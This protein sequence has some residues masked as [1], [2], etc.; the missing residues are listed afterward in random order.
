MNKNKFALGM[1]KN[2]TIR[3]LRCMKYFAKSIL[4]MRPERVKQVTAYPLKNKVIV[5]LGDSIFGN[6]DAPNDISTKIAELTG[7]TVYNCGFGGCRMARHVSAYYDPFSMYRL[8]D[9]IVSRDFALQEQ[10]LKMAK[11]DERQTGLLIFKFPKTLSKLKKINFNKVDIVTISYGT[12]DWLG[13]NDLDND[14]DLLDVDSLAGALR[15]SIEKM[16]TK[17]PHLKIF[18]CSP[19]YRCWNNTDGSLDY[20]TDNLSTSVNGVRFIDIIDKQESVARE[21]NLSFVD[22]YHKLGINKINRLQY[23]SVED[24]THPNLAGRQLIAEHIAKCLF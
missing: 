3:F 6:F 2:K 24:G 23:F 15:Y 1:I 7:A 16:L 5:N 12:N 17:Y 20:D 22:N 4:S 9:A 11:K 13:G 18:I 19:I 10:A 8:A 21:Y 14:N